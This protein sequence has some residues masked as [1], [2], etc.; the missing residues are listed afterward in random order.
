MKK[1][2]VRVNSATAE[3]HSGS[4]VA[5]RGVDMSKLYIDML[6]EKFKNR[7][8]K[9]GV[10]LDAERQREKDILFGAVTGGKSAPRIVSAY[11]DKYRT[12]DSSGMSYMTSDNFAAYYKDLRNYKMP[13]FCSRAESEYEAAAAENVQ[14][15]GKPPKKAMWL[16]VTR[17]AKIK[18]KEMPSYFTK[19]GL[20][21]LSDEWFP[22][23]SPDD[24]GEGK[25]KRMP[26]GVLPTLSIL[27][28]SLLLIVCS[29]VMVS[30]ASA[31]NSSLEYK[32]DNL[33]AVKN[34]LEADLDVKNDMLDIKRI[35]VEEYGMI[36]GE[37]AASRYVDVTEDE[38]IEVYGEKEKSES[39]LSQILRAIGLKDD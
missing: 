36:S 32:L 17:R 8:I 26:R 11:D 15:S 30:R 21:K 19:E 37:Y 39:L 34:D 18:L 13:A 3:L 16:A 12:R 2:R 27:A 6:C 24:R 4:L 22:I 5:D 9:T 23:D 14:E 28:I 1:E 38:K 33:I 35:A 10:M 29:S 25:K 31:K 20:A 7:G